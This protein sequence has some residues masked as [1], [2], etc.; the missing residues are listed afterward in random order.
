MC[1]PGCEAVAQVIVDNGLTDFYHKRT[2]YSPK[3]N[4][5]PD[6]LE[7]VSHYSNKPTD[8]SPETHNEHDLILEGISCSACIW[9]LEHRLR[10]LTGVTSFK[11]N[12]ATRRAHIKSK[13]DQVQLKQIIEAIQSIGYD[14][15]P[16]DPTKQYL[17]LQQE[18]KDYLSRIG[19]AIF[20]G[21]QVMM[22][23][24][25]I[26]ISEIDE[27][28]PLLLQ[29]LIW[30]SAFLTTPVVLYS[31]KPF[32][33][34]AVRDINNRSLGMDVP[35]ALGIGL[36]FIASIYN[37]IQNTG[38]TYYESVC[39]FVIFLL[40]AR[41]VE[42]LTRWY[43]ISASEHIT[44]NTTTLA[45]KIDSQNGF[46][47]VNSQALRVGDEILINPGA[48][49]PADSIV[50]SGSS[51]IDESILTGEK[52]PIKK[53]EG[54]KLLG[55][56]HNVDN[57]LIAT[58]SCIGEDSTL[59]TITRLITQAQ[60]EKPSWV[61][62]ADRYASWFVLLIIL[63]TGSSAFY[64]WSIADP[65]W[66]S[67]ALSVLV[68]TCPCA[69][70]LATPTAYTAT[71]SQL[72]NQGIIVTNGQAMEKLTATDH[73]VFD[74]T[75]TLT[76]GKMVVKTCH[77]QSASHTQQF[78]FDIAASLEALSDHPIAQAFRSTKTSTKIKVTDVT[79][80][81]G[82][83][84]CG[85]VNGI[86]YYLG[87][88]K[89][90][91]N[92]LER[93]VT[94]QNTAGTLI[95]LATNDELIAIF[96]INDSVR[97]GVKDTLSWLAKQGKSVS[98]LSGDQEASVSWFSKKIGISKYTS[99]ASPAEKLSYIEQ[100]QD[101][102]HGV[103]MIGDGINDAPVL[104]KADVS[105]A[106]ST[107]SQ[108]ARASSDILLL[109]HDMNSLK[110]VFILSKMTKQIILQNMSWALIYNLGAL[111][112]ALLGHVQ[113]WQA[114]LGMS[115]SSLIVVLNSFRIRLQSRSTT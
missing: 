55:G 63:L 51:W 48:I 22:I 99:S 8:K 20:C 71:M 81:T 21:M 43:A 28:D 47:L 12:Y 67:T 68:V 103:A 14:A 95:Y 87:S 112:L 96:E 75:G 10:Q 77:M 36:A 5:V 109:R 113:P 7:H 37:S 30:T 78:A 115:I 104:A 89:L 88:I 2:A 108:L 24:L 42:F 50:K 107:A 101:H 98:L 74:K 61:T 46:T 79:H 38:E 102:G 26:Y 86:Q 105:I 35:V 80:K 17:K 56:S 33:S 76:E 72:F 16:Y 11:V 65:N 85:K 83:G 62:L 49:I 19:I 31:A 91:E 52:T 111:P 66:F 90:V 110:Q 60:T 97:D 34:S 84:I 59:S 70:S 39:M 13:P 82:L 73:V 106:V 40:I 18:R 114:A 29:F 94:N 45:K 1:C 58:V 15:Y 57:N 69:L 44:Q 93:P 92:A 41:Y 9:L 4:L 53:H 27:I 25:G 6:E 100:L 23:T 54:D 32:F 64:G 3:A